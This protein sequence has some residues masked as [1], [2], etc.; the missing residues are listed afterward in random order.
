MIRYMKVRT[1]DRLI[2]FKFTVF[3]L[4]FT[5]AGALLPLAMGVETAPFGRLLWIVIGFL[6]ARMAGMSLNDLIDREIDARNPRTENRVLPMGEASPRQALMIGVLGL[7]IFGY[8]CARINLLVLGLAV[9]A[10]FLIWVYPFTKRFTALCHFVLGLVHMMAPIMAWA[11]MTGTLAWPPVLLGACALC[12][13]V[14]NDVVWALQDYK[15]DV[16]NGLHSVPVRIGPAMALM[17][18]RLLYSG[19]VLCLAGAGLI[20][21]LPWPFYIGVLSALGAVLYYDRVLLKQGEE[22]IPAAFFRCN[23]VVAGSALLG[24][25][26]TFLL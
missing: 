2:K 14:A 3:G 19:A 1:L 21:N 17:L 4:P 13:I 8:A 9:P 16:E 23:A 7:F 12:T 22:G 10:G 24:V 18:S 15:F 25:V 26:L 6:G 5:L 20:A 11:A